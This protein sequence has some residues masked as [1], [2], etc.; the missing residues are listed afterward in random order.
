MIRSRA[1]VGLG[2]ALVLLM[3]VPVAASVVF[4][5]VDLAGTDPVA[6]AVPMATAA[7]SAD[8]AARLGIPPLAVDSY[9]KAAGSTDACPGMAWWLLAGIGA[10]ETNHGRY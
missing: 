6:S 7:P 4:L 1:W 2:V 8:S 10:I 5:G 3:A 9:A